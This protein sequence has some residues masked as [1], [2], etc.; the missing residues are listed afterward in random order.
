MPD[1]RAYVR[2]SLPSLGIHPKREREIVEELALQLEAAYDAAI[3]KGADENSARRTAESEVPDWRTLAATLVH[4]EDV[5][6]RRRAPF[7][8]FAGD[9][10]VA[11]RA[12]RRTP[13]FT[14]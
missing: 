6:A 10:R 5:P 13:S 8:G 12:L 9:L 4:V 11:A 1:W 2:S 7:A 3:A 14:A